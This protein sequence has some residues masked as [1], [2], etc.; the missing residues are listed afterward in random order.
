M[1][2]AMIASLMALGLVSGQEWRTTAPDPAFAERMARKPAEDWGWKGAVYDDVLILDSLSRRPPQCGL[3][4]FYSVV[5]GRLP[6]GETAFFYQY[7]C[8]AG[9]PVPP[10]SG[11]CRI[12]VTLIPG[13][14]GNVPAPGDGPPA[15]A[16]RAERDA[17]PAK[18]IDNFSCTISSDSPPVLPSTEWPPQRSAG[19]GV[20][21]VAP[22]PPAPSIL[23][24]PAPVRD[25][26]TFDDILVTRI[27]DRPAFGSG[28]MMTWVTVT[29]VTTAGEPLTWAI[30]YMGEGQ[31]LPPV[32]G[33]CHFVSAPPMA[34]LAD[35]PELAGAA[36]IVRRFDCTISSDSPTVSPDA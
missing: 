12:G 27:S 2:T 3:I 28:Y 21:D 13:R 19:R 14:D 23:P 35:L 24:Q 25:D 33:R 18:M 15:T 36:M 5:L 7:V 10:V 29:G 11:R 20:N 22:S 1:A 32:S 9:Q 4:T 34:G 17:Y 6:T 26:V 30:T 16:S 31:P 8:T